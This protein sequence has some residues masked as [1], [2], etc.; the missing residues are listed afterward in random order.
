MAWQGVPVRDQARCPPS[1]SVLDYGENY[2]TFSA[3][4][5]QHPLGVDRRQV[6]RIYFGTPYGLVVVARYITLYLILGVSCDFNRH[7]EYDVRHFVKN[8][9]I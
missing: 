4:R 2:I 5:S 8:K 9:F 1:P 3:V 6:S 7:D